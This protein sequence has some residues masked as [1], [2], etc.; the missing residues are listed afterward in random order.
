MSIYKQ[1]SKPLFIL[2]IATFSLNKSENDKTYQ[3]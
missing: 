2:A 1:R 3:I